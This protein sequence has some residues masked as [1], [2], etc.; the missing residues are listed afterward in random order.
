VPGAITTSTLAIVI[1][2]Y[3]VVFAG[4]ATAGELLFDPVA[5]VVLELDGEIVNSALVDELV[6]NVLE[7]LLRVGVVTLV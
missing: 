2:S 6:M 1:T 3:S 7:V 5:E 4:T